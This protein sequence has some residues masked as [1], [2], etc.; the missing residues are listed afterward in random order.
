MQQPYQSTEL[1]KIWTSAIQSKAVELKRARHKKELPVFI[2]KRQA[3]AATADHTRSNAAY[4]K[5][6]AGTSSQQQ[7]I[8]QTSAGTLMDHMY[9]E[10]SRRN[11]QHQGAEKALSWFCRH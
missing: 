5:A 6:T 3:P 11:K 9:G 8:A 2:Q 10:G 1:N 7:P 4:A